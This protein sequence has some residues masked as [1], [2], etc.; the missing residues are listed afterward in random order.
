ML[1]AAQMDDERGGRLDPLTPGRLVVLLVAIV[2]LAAV[3]V[4]ASRPGEGGPGAPPSSAATGAA[5]I[6]ASVILFAIA[7]AGVLGLIVWALWPEGKRREIRTRRGTL[8][9]AIA[10]FLQGAGALVLFW[11]YL[12]Y[13]AGISGSRG[14][15]LPAFGAPVA[16]PG[17]QGGPVNGTAGQGWVTALLVVAVLAIG[18]GLALRGVRFRHRRWALA[19]VAEQLQEAAEESLEML[20]SEADPRRAV[21]AAYARMELALAQVGLPRARHETALEYLDRVL[22]LLRARG[23]AA[24]RLTELFQLAK[25]SDHPI[26]GEM[27][28]EAIGAL[29]ELRVD[30]RERAA[31]DEI[32]PRTMPA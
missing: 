11:Y 29:H 7:E 21:I 15:I 8:A 25:F 20:R 17:I 6:R 1:G 9:I 14:G 12:R 32:E 23:P 18:A 22:G 3:V 4:S 19:R 5:V 28:R 10:S 2:A 31:E 13:R 26:D 24:R 27:Q 30:L 16:L